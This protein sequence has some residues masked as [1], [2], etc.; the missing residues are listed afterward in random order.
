MILCPSLY[1]PLP[2]LL[3]LFNENTI[4]FMPLLKKE[5]LFFYFKA[6][7]RNWRYE[8]YRSHLAWYFS[9]K[10][11]TIDYTHKYLY[12]SA[13]WARKYWLLWGN[14]TRSIGC[15]IRTLSQKWHGFNVLGSF[16]WTPA[17]LGYDKFG[18]CLLWRLI[19]V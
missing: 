6:R 18:Y 11:K 10:N 8:K 4:G 5:Y 2:S 17:L 9:W 12:R 16:L 13:S 19:S 1:Q 3:A 7:L 15:H 14:D